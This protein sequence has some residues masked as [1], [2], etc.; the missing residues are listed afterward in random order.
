MTAAY[1]LHTSLPYCMYVSFGAQHAPDNKDVEATAANQA[2]QIQLASGQAAGHSGRS[3]CWASIA[4]I[5]LILLK[6][7]TPA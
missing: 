4:H 7:Q 1:C 2:H 5:S 3:N 6:R